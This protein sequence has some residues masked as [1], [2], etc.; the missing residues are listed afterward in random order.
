MMDRWRNL[1]RRIESPKCPERLLEDSSVLG[2]TTLYFLIRLLF[3]KIT[4]RFPV[5]L[6]IPFFGRDF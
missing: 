2:C 5:I 4:S 6:I 1:Q 3:S